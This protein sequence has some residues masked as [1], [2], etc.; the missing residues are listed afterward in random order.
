ML[1]IRR[2]FSIGTPGR[3]NGDLEESVDNS[4]R[5]F[6]PPT[7][8]VRHLSCFQAVVEGGVH[9]GF[10]A[11]AL[12]LLR[13]G[14]GSVLGC[15][16]RL[17]LRYLLSRRCCLRDGCASA[18][19]ALLP[20][21]LLLSWSLR[22]R[23]RY[24]DGECSLRLSQSDY[25][26]S[27]MRLALLLFGER[28]ALDGAT[29]LIVGQTIVVVEVGRVVFFLDLVVHVDFLELK[30]HVGNRLLDADVEVGL[31]EEIPQDLHRQLAGEHVQVVLDGV[32]ERLGH[33]VSSAA[34]GGI[35]LYRHFAIT[36]RDKQV[37]RDVVAV[38]VAFVVLFADVTNVQLAV[39]VRLL[40][41]GDVY[42]EDRL[43]IRI[44]GL[45]GLFHARLVAKG[46]RQYLDIVSQL[47]TG[48]VIA[49]VGTTLEFAA[50]TIS[51]YK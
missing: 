25:L 46:H 29:E 23:L 43:P 22:S 18:R 24:L 8:V 3:L 36:A 26:T 37:V 17:V 44:F 14:V 49:E 5:K 41:P 32:L 48:C 6:W 12:S 33:V 39:V 1:C 7:Q 11:R 15:R 16:C 38:D 4:C 20:A 2:L 21:A 10:G 40:S 19:L 50:G 45:L 30:G 27:V 47:D 51:S 34:V 35:S 28:V 42:P 13:R 31:G 9:S